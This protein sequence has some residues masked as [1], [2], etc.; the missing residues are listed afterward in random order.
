[1]NPN[2]ATAEVH[3]PTAI[4][5]RRTGPQNPFVEFEIEWTERS[6]LNRFRCVARNYHERIALKTNQDTYS[7]RDIDEIS[8]RLG[9]AILSNRGRFPEPVALLLEHD[10]AVP[11]AMLGVLKAGK[12]YVTLDP[13]Y[14]QEGA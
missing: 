13:F 11:A 6:I 9:Q 7:Y 5:V 12:F 14:P 1:M 2:S 10:A 3:K 8:S 4:G